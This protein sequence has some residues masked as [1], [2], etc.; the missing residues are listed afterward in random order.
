MLTATHH[1]VRSPQ[2]AAARRKEGWAGLGKR[3]YRRMLSLSVMLP[4]LQQAS[5]INSVIYFSSMVRT[6]P[7]NGNSPAICITTRLPGVDALL[8]CAT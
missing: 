6:L 8:S 4:L 1:A 5:G 7:L 2:A 3:E